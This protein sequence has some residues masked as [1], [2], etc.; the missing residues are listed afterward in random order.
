MAFTGMIGPINC[1]PSPTCTV[2]QPLNDIVIFNLAGYNYRTIPEW[3]SLSG[4]RLIPLE[5]Y[6]DSIQNIYSWTF[7]KPRQSYLSQNCGNE[8]SCF[9]LS[10]SDDIM[11]VITEEISKS[12]MKIKKIR[13]HNGYTIWSVNFP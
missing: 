13:R 6:F 9:Y 2:P 3:T 10:T 5:F 4:S 7:G 8:S 11:P 12:I 1:C